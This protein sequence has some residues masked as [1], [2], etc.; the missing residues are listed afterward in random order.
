MEFGLII[1]IV[2]EHTSFQLNF[3][4]THFHYEL[5]LKFNECSYLRLAQEFLEEF[6]NS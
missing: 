3:F 2:L 6:R 5:S 1:L 4:N